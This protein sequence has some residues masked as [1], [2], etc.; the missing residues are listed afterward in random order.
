VHQEVRGEAKWKGDGP[1]VGKEGGRKVGRREQPPQGKEAGQRE[2]AS[3]PQQD[4]K[5]L[6]ARPRFRRNKI[7]YGTAKEG[8]GGFEYVWDLC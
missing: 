5:P 8:F 1:A 4:G 3:Q 2:G 6:R 7:T